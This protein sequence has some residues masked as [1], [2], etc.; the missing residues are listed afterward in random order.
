MASELLRLFPAAMKV[1]FLVGLACGS[2]AVLASPPDAR[3]LMSRAVK[4]TEA[5][6]IQAPGYSFTRSDVKTKHDAAPVR[7]RYEVLMIEGSPYLK[8]IAQDGQ[9]LSG[10]QAEAQEQSYQREISRRQHESPRERRKRIEK[11]TADRNRDH[12]LLME[13]CDAFDYTVAGEESLGG[14]DVWVLHGTPKRDYVPKNREGKVLAGMEVTFWIDKQ[15]YQWPRIE[16]EVKTPVSFY[17]AIGKVDPGTRFLLEQ[18]PVSKDLWL[19]KHFQ[20]HVIATALGFINEDSSSEETYTN[21]RQAGP[22]AA[23]SA[24]APGSSGGTVGT[25]AAVR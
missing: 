7:N 9:P 5:N 21:Y 3:E 18:E 8:L 6:W 10:T 19:P 25:L 2:M 23:A 20:V 4:V 24:Q 11:F 12:A 17:G 22:E 16:A 13:L 1:R 15:T 14:R